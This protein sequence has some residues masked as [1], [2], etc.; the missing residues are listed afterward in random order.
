MENN[1]E[2]LE[3]VITTELDHKPDGIRLKKITKKTTVEEKHEWFDREK[4]VAE[5]ESLQDHKNKDI[6]RLEE[7]MAAAIIKWDAR[8]AEAKEDIVEFDANFGE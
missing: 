4:L 5:V 8:I 3:P 6:V 1:E 7:E 2:I